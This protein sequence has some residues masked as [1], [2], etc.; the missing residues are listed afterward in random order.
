MRIV[1]DDGI[2]LIKVNT[3]NNPNPELTIRMEGIG[4]SAFKSNAERYI[5]LPSVLAMTL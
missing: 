5:I 1:N 2:A 3:N 4:F